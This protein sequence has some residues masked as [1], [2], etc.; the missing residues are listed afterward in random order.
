MLRHSKGAHSL[1]TTAKGMVFLTRKPYDPISFVSTRFRWAP[2]II[3][4][5]FSSIWQ[6][7][8][9]A[10]H[11]FSSD[12]PDRDEVLGTLLSVSEVVSA[13]RFCENTTPGPDR[14]T[15]NHWR[16]LDPRALSLTKLFNCCI[17]LR[18]I[19]RSWKESTTILL[20]KSG[21]VS[22]PSKSLS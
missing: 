14:L 11:F 13:F 6:E 20:P 8:L 22:C 9:S 5:H 12:Y 4:E 15:Y 3:E 18:T 7:S 21:D 17:H 2:S 1:L 16:S 19:P 10:D